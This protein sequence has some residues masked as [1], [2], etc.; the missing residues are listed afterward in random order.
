LSVPQICSNRIE[1][2]FRG[3]LHEFIDTPEGANSF[4]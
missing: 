4:G 3:V 1:F 2:L